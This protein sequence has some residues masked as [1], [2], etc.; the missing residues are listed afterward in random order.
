MDESLQSKRQLNI[1]KPDSVTPPGWEDNT[2][3]E[4]SSLE[5]EY[6]MLERILQP[7]GIDLRKQNIKF[8]E[9]GSGSGHFLNFLKGEGVQAEGIDAN[10]RGKN[11]ELITLGDI[12][13]LPF[14]DASFN[15]IFSSQVFD[16]VNYNQQN[17]SLMIEEIRRVLVSGG[18]YV[19]NLEVIDVPMIG[20]D[21][22]T[23]F[24]PKSKLMIAYKKS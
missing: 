24:P 2:P 7:Y 8:L 6:E 22:P 21:E 12:E 10:P 18:V 20:F 16:S 15:V 23:Y 3:E 19:G 4:R 1:E 14:E 17:Q 9:V 11:R 5:F 13:K